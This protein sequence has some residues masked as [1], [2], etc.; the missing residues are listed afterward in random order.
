MVVAHLVTG[1]A[2]TTTLLRQQSVAGET[3]QVGTMNSVGGTNIGY[4]S[5]E[6]YCPVPNTPQY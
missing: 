6:K 1:A 5:P 3:Q 4:H 2:L